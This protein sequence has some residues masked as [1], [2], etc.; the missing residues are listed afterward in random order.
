[1]TSVAHRTGQPGGAAGTVTMVAG[2]AAEYAVVCLLVVFF[3]LPLLWLVLTPFS[4]VPSYRAALSGFTLDNFRDLL[5]NPQTW[6]SIRNSLYL[7]VGSSVLVIVLAALAAYALSRVRVP[8]RDQ[9][10][11]GLLL[12]VAN[13]VIAVA[14]IRL[15]RSRSP[16]EATA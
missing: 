10:L 12:L 2:K 9:L 5:S 3:A 11:Y 7:A 14:Y 8:G 13:L 16:E 4:P 15:L 1:M 6:P